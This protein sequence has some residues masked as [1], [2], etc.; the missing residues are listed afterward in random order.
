MADRIVR[1]STPIE[2]PQPPPPGT[3]YET[4]SPIVQRRMPPAAGDPQVPTSS[5]NEIMA[6]ARTFVEGTKGGEVNSSIGQNLLLRLRQIEDS[7][8]RGSYSDE[9]RRLSSSVE[10]VMKSGKA[11]SFSSEGEQEEDYTPEQSDTDGSLSTS[12]SSS[13]FSNSMSSSMESSASMSD[14]TGSLGY[15]SGGRRGVLITSSGGKAYAI[16]ASEAQRGVATMLDPN[17]EIDGKKVKITQ[18]HDKHGRF[19][20]IFEGTYHGAVVIVK[21][22]DDQSENGVRLFTREISMLNEA[23]GSYTCQLIGW[24]TEPLMFVTT[25]YARTLEQALSGPNALSLDERVRVIYQIGACLEHIHS[26]GIVHLDL[27]P[28]NIYLDAHNNARVGDFGHACFVDSEDLRSRTNRGNL[29]H[30]SPEDLRGEL[31][32]QKSDVYAFG[33]LAYEVFFGPPYFTTRHQEER[34]FVAYVTTPGRNVI[35]VTE[36]SWMEN[37]D[38]TTKLSKGFWRAMMRCWSAD[39]KERPTMKEIVAEIYKHG[40]RSAIPRSETTEKFWRTCCEDTYKDRLEVAQVARNAVFVPNVNPAYVLGA[41]CRTSGVITIREFWRLCCWFPN[42]FNDRV[43]E[44]EMKQAFEQRW[45]ALTKEEGR[46]RLRDVPGGQYFVVFPNPTKTLDYPFTLYQSV[47]GQR[48]EVP[49]VRHRSTV[50]GVD[51]YAF[52][53]NLTGKIEFESLFA[54]TDFFVRVKKYLTP[55]DFDNNYAEG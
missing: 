26:R 12:A 34:D 45:F 4:L 21:M 37:D 6:E 46:R 30:R 41:V 23:R 24:C 52:T 43:M 11:L 22:L 25:R 18:R 27:K 54:I 17:G 50:E 38:D 28:S 13:T 9:V 53:C 20:R 2:I 32:S 33:L 16:R 40:V 42:W 1:P 44:I 19:G 14:T 39:P 3:C 51:G 31:P 35:P 48:T 8:G 55:P 36:V 5:V 47:D 49:I 29:M 15:S 7:L 10:A